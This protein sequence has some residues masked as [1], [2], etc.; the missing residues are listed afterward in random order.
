MKRTHK[1]IPVRAMLLTLFMVLLLPAAMLRAQQLTSDQIQE[2]KRQ[3]GGMTNQEIDQKIKS[4][5]MTRE[6]AMERAK[7]NGIDLQTFLRLPGS[8]AAAQSPQGIIQSGPQGYVM[9]QDSLSGLR[10]PAV[11]PKRTVKSENGLTYFGYEIFSTTPSAFEPTASGPI[12]PEYIIGPDDVLRVSVWGQVEQQNE[13]T[14]DIEGRVFLPTAGPVVVSGLTIEEVKKTLTK[15]LSRSF[16]GLTAS[17]KTM[18][19]DV[20]LVKVKPKR[21]FIMGEVENPGGYTVSSYAN[22]FNSLFA[23]GGPTV[24][25]SLRD[26]RLIRGNK[27]IAKVDLYMYLTGSEKN[28]DL[29]VQNNDI[30]Y[31]P[32]RKNTIYLRGKIRRPA[33]YELLPGENIKKL[34]EYA[35][36]TLPTSYLERIQVERIIPLKERVK[37]DIERRMIDINYR[38]IL[39]KNSDVPLADGDIITLFPILGEVKNYVTISGSVFKPGTYQLTPN[40]KL[41]D[42]IMLADSLRPETY[43]ARGEITRL[44]NDNM[45]RISIPFDVKALMEGDQTNNITLNPKDDVILHSNSISRLEDEFVEIFGNVKKPGKYLLTKNMTLVDVLMLADGY[46]ENASRLQAEIARLDET[47]KIDTLAFINI[48]KLPDLL[49][50]INING[51]SFFE[52]YRKNDLRLKHRDQIFIR[53]NPNF[54][55]QQV[56]TISG[57]VNYPGEYALI[58]FNEYLSDIVQRSGGPTLAAYLR[59]AKLY[60]GRQRVN[61]DFQDVM[62][63]PKST[64]DII[65]RSGDSIDVPKKPNAVKMTG[66]VNN[67]GLLGFI[68]GEEV[69]D[70]IDRAG[71]LTDSADFVVLYHPNGNAEKFNTGWFS[72]STKVYDGSTINVVKIPPPQ[73]NDQRVDIGTLI[74][75]IFAITASA[76]TI[77]VL[78]RQ[79]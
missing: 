13:L 72:G 78:T 2:A 20:S 70:Y 19:M 61:V 58:T 53:P 77:L 29:R 69:W 8:A 31:V 73:I 71:G 15:Q 65:L 33:I 30:I 68:N 50:T 17:P 62:N 67:P 55:I 35:G 5:G 40:M 32:V 4:L 57:E 43:V 21:V 75:D 49:D 37:N 60:R 36:G 6:E 12:D 11:I 34:I 56:V 42:L 39:L 44:L 25:G 64:K 79:L 16:Q 41:K 45:T 23:V 63:A 22:I 51:Y 27:T 54:R 28:N 9:P 74:K 46:T 59:G 47:K 18:W 38:E 14:V 10:F 1:G 66:E 76:L 48:A 26:I 7:E 24:Q 52:E 3:L